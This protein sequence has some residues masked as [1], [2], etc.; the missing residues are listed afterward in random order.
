MKLNTKA[1]SGFTLIELLVVIAIIA[2]LAG[3]L[4][5][6]LANA[7][8]KAQRIS[9]VNNLKQVTLAVKM[10]AND[11]T[12][13]YP[14]QLTAVDGGSAG[15]Q[16][17]WE[18]FNIVSNEL[19]NPKI[20][21]CPSDAVRP[22]ATGFQPNAANTHLAA[23]GNLAVS[24]GIHVE[25]VEK[26]ANQH[27]VVDRN[28]VGGDG[29][30]GTCRGPANDLTAIPVR[31]LRG[32]LAAPGNWT[33]DLHNNQGNMSLVDGSTQQYS[34]DRLK[35]QLQAPNNYNS[36]DGNLSNCTNLPTPETY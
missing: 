5:P 3:L 6:A 10:F 33:A 14:W 21:A 20:L 35:R 27:L 34:Q 23:K 4:L 36:I 11:N 26:G 16:Q 19:A 13:K 31:K 9:C 1:R 8:K 17:T 29:G 28:L 22:A 32:T 12:D 15:R 2:I 30:F 7:K 24:Y 25:A 18:H